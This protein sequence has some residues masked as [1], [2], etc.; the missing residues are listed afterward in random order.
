MS[1]LRNLLKGQ[2]ITDT[3]ADN[4][5][6]IGGRVFLDGSAVAA[7]NDLA[8]IVE[9]WRGVHVPTYGAPIPATGALSTHAMV[10]SD[11]ENVVDVSSGVLKV[12]AVSLTNGGPAPILW[13]VY[14]GGVRLNTDP[15]S[16]DPGASGV[17]AV[18]GSLFIDENTPLQVKITSGTPTDGVV[19][20]S[21]VRVA[22]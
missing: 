20:V 9:S 13:E 22:F 11:L 5:A 18:P 8:R 10:G 17:Y 19:D 12:Q 2:S 6:T 1:D 7:L 4:L 3:S 14:V 21:T 15:L 16:A